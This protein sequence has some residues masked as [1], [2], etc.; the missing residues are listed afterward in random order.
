MHFRLGYV[1]ALFWV[2]A[3]HMDMKISINDIE[4]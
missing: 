4:R 3:K 1:I 2:V